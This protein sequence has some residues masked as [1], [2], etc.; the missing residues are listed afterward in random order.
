MLITNSVVVTCDEPNEVLVGYSVL[1]Q[2]EQIIDILPDSK[3][4]ELYPNEPSYNADGKL[5]LPG[6]V[7]AHTHF[8]GAFSRGM[9]IP[10]DAPQNFYEILN[11]LWWPLDKSLTMEDV[12]YSS[13][14]C[15]VDAIKHGTTTLFDH[16]A[17]PAAID[18]SL[19]VIADTVKR[20]GLRA[21]LCYEVTDRGG[22]A[23]RDNGIKE[24]L[25]FIN[26]VNKDK[27]N[28]L[29]GFFGLHAAI[30]LSEE[31]LEICAAEKNDNFGFHTHLS[32]SRD[33]QAHTQK[34]FNM[35]PVPLMDKYGILGPRSI[36]AHCVHISDADISLLKERGVWV[37]H[38]PRSN[39]NN[40][41]GVARVE[42]MFSEGIKV[43]LGNDG[44]SNSM[45]DEMK[46]A[47][48]IHKSEN[49]DPTRMNGYTLMDIALKNNSAMA[50][51]FFNTNLGKIKKGFAA[52]LMIVNYRPPTELNKYNFPWHLLFGFRES[53]IESTMVKGKFLMLDRELLTLDEK[54]ISAK[55]VELSK[56]VWERYNSKF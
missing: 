31:T 29:V 21:A 25:R 7:C 13:L 54:E 52:D 41:V 27:L 47:Y 55:C 35:D 2:G 50:S 8:Y 43:T 10:G 18:G 17:S 1:V 22:M 3:A 48:L 42:K 26:K 40:A 12:E 11:K 5:V 23:E 46:T 9:A 49:S 16:H 51:T 14:L 33:D 53:M 56:K 32:E 39:M 19:D 15:E 28:D 45:W 6:N 24:N 36:I 30:T 37:T 20:S 44:F 38:Q 34:M 4:K